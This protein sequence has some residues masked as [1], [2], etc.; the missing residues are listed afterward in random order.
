ME[1]INGQ[2]LG[3]RELAKRVLSWITCAKRPLTKLELQHALAIEVGNLELDEENLPQIEDM[4]SVCAG[5]VTIDQES[6]I[7]RL[8]HHTTQEYFERTQ[9]QWFPNAEADIT[10]ICV[11]YLSFSVFESGFCQTDEEFEERLRLYQLYDYAAHNWGHHARNAKTLFQE[12]VDFLQCESKVKASSQALFG[13]ESSL[14]R[15]SRQVIGLHLAAY[16]GVREAVPS[17]LDRYYMDIKDAYGRTSLLLAAA[18]GH[19]DVVDL[20]CNKSKA[21]VDLKTPL[22]CA[23]TNGHAGVVQLLLAKGANVD[24]K[25]KDG[26]TPLSR[27]AL[28]GHEAVVKVLLDAGEIHLDSK[29]MCGQTSLMQA[30]SNGFDNIARLLLAKGANPGSRNNYGETPL[31]CAASYGH[32]AAVKLLLYT[33]K[34]E[35]DLK[36]IYGFTPLMSAASQGHK[37]VVKLLLGHG[38]VDVNSADYKLGGTALFYSAIN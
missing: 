28:N 36:D 5:L 34:G 21:D 23:A 33:S 20:L 30:A 35:A 31:K 16:F 38:K 6:D 25:C 12:V 1:R 9:N 3:L 7:I 10:K 8:I 24:W 27:A 37:A 19:D 2:K 17:L 14:S 18:N 15:N 26:Q 29:D 13:A 32:E 11:T 22:L 4:I